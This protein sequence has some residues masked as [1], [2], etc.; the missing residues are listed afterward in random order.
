MRLWNIYLKPAVHRVPEFWSHEKIEYIR[1][2]S[3]E[4]IPPY[5][6]EEA[7]SKIGRLLD[8]LVFKDLRPREVNELLKKADGLDVDVGL[9]FFGTR[10]T[11]PIYLGDMSFGALSGN[12]NI[13]IAK[14]STEE[15]MVAGI[16]EGGLHPEVAKYRNIVVQWASARFGMDMALLRAGLAVNIKIGQGAKPGIGGHLPGVKV[17]KIIAELRKIPEGSEALSP[18][19]HHDIYSIEDLAQRVKAL[20]DLTGKPVLVKVAAVNKIMYVAVG[21]SRSTAEG[22]II[23]GAGAGTGATPISVR[24]HLGIP[25]DYAIPVVDKWLRENGARSNFLVIG[26]GMLYS[27]SDIAKL[28]ALGADMANIGTAALLSFGCIM[29]HSCHTGGCPT[30]LTNMIGARPDLDIEW[31]SAMLRRYLR[32]LRLGLKAILYSLGMDS[33]KELAGRRD[34]L[35]LYYADE[36]VASTI[37]VDLMAEGEIAYFQEYAPTMP[38]EVYEEGKVPIIGMGGVVPGYTY[39]ARRPLD[40]LRI[41][42]AQVTHPS[43]D[44]YREEVDV[45]VYVNG[46][47]YDTPIVVPGLERAAVMAGY[48]LGALV[49]GAGCPE[50]EYCLSTLPHVRLP[51]S[52]DIEPRE[53]IVII[54]ERLKGD[55]WLE[56]AVALLDEKARQAGIREKMTII[57]AGRLSSGADVYKLAALG[58][59]LVEPREAFELLA[60]RQAPSYAAKRRWYENLISVLTKELKLAMGAGGITDYYH[61]VG[62]K[63]LLRSLDGRIAARLNVPVAGN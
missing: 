38:R 10:L 32:A 55:A 61:M 2:S 19:P 34:L 54:D 37:G 36:A 51:P 41:E 40:L 30:S 31:A 24:N 4:G 20:R 9:D 58:A 5:A 6:L 60:S 14:V 49:D 47:S 16:G 18:A 35:G 25:I 26:G 62:N 46:F 7:P 42:A 50:P 23:D 11:A 43:V 12:P 22:I 15:G 29:C 53:G 63:D 8:R 21:V 3:Q 28:I 59:D 57:A 33:L 44:P 17:T 52:R 13:A 45:R 56:E 39:P 48:A 27:A 1:R